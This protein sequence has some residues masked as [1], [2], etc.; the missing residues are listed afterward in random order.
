MKARITVLVGL[1][2]LVAAPLAGGLIRGLPRAFLELPPTT[3]Y[4]VHAPFSRPLFVLFAFLAAVAAALL[5]R[6]RWFGFR[7]FPVPPSSHSALG[8]QHS[9]FLP[10][11]AWAGIALNLVS[12][13]CAWIRPNQL[14]PLKD[15][16]F[17]P[18]WLGYILAVDGLVFRRT[19]TSMLVRSPARWLALFPASAA[20]WWYFE[21]LNRFV[22]NW[23]YQ[24][25]LRFSALHYVSFGTLCFATV[26][27]AVFET[28]DAL[29]S[30]GWFQT[31][32]RA[33][34]CWKAPGRPV[35]A[36]L[37]AAGALGLVLLALAPNPMFFMT[38]LAPLCLLAGSLAL[39]GAET[40]FSDLKNGDYRS[41]FA[42]AVAALVCGFFWEMWNFGS[43]PKWHY[44]VPY[45]GAF[46]VFEMPVVGYTG[47]LPF[48]PICWCLG[49]AVEVLFAKR[50]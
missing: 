29:M 16:L 15:H 31:A 42:L 14:G 26:L 9:A 39:A 11:W 23:W 38:W 3:Q 22:Q 49:Q 4:V 45:V 20:V 18:L 40:P 34:P 21:Y 17:F 27:P 43:L 10:L 37:T 25:V 12:W 5:L 1:V 30:F 35:L 24:G 6:P 41:L 48:G 2:L 50:R 8:T 47:Y 46:K 33:G 36:A 44:T 13:T 19:G 28:R 7:P 32:Y